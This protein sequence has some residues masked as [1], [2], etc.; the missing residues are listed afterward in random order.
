MR[1]YYCVECDDTDVEIAAYVK[2]NDGFEYVQEFEDYQ[3]CNGYC[4][5][6]EQSV[7]VSYREIPDPKTESL[8][9]FKCK[10]CGHEFEAIKTMSMCSG[11]FSNNIYKKRK[12]KTVGSK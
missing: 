12:R 5:N 2:P 8:V 9:E 11:C 10:D 6:C 1:E 7:D 3:N 4:N